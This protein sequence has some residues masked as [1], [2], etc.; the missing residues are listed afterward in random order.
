MKRF[1]LT[2]ILTCKALFSVEVDTS[3]G[4]FVAP[5]DGLVIYQ[6]DF[7]QGSSSNIDLSH[8]AHLYFN[9]DIDSE[10]EYVP[11]L[12]L[13]YTRLKN[14]GSSFVRLNT[15]SNIVNDIIASAGGPDFYLN[16]KLTYYMYDWY[17]YYEYRYDE[18]YPVL[19]YG[20]GMKNILYD[21]EVELLEGMQFNDKGDASLPM[22]YL[23]VRKDFDPLHFGLEF[24][25]SYYLF[26]DSIIY[27]YRL[28][29]DYLFYLNDKIESGFE[30]GFR[31]FYMNVIGNDI[32]SI[33]GNMSYNGFFFGIYTNFK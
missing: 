30:I 10:I 22:L 32:D 14:S 1:L 13:E 2:F 20:L 21:Y 24:E 31:D 11:Q 29:A 7:F 18:I 15:Q 16:S 3:F 6:R 25:S 27:D 33:S 12:H 26:G 5:A 17:L 8:N 23:N 28:R 9:I 4:L 19:K